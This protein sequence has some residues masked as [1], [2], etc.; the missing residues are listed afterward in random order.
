MRES[1]SDEKVAVRLR[2]AIRRLGVSTMP[3][4]AQL[5]SVGDS[6]LAQR[7]ARSGGFD[8]WASKIGA[9]PSQ[10]ASR[11]GWEWEAWVASFAGAMGANVERRSRVKEPWDLK[12]NGRTVDV[13]VSYGKIVAGGPQW[14]WRIGRKEH[15]CEFYVLIAQFDGAPPVPHICP[16][17][18]IPLT[19]TTARLSGWSAKWR[20]RWDL[21]TT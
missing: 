7:I 17:S 2:A 10:H 20:Y 4:A 9:S 14:T 13:K 21:L 5:V 18:V 16:S 19:C 11:K 8:M 1:W 3:T 6:S 12:I 15:V